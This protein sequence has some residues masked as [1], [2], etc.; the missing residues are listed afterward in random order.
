MLLYT[1]VTPEILLMSFRNKTQVKNS[2]Y[3]GLIDENFPDDVMSL[4]GDNLVIKESKNTLNVDIALAIAFNSIR[5]CDTARQFARVFIANGPQIDTKTLLYY[6]NRILN[7]P[8][9]NCVV[10]FVDVNF[11]AATQG[12]TGANNANTQRNLGGSVIR[13][14]TILENYNKTA[15]YDELVDVSF[16]SF[17]TNAIKDC[18]NA[19]CNYFKSTGSYGLL[20]NTFGTTNTPTT[21]SGIAIAGVDDIETFNKIPPIFQRVGIQLSEMTTNIKQSLA[22][23]V[24]STKKVFT[25]D[26]TYTIK[27]VPISTSSISYDSFVRSSTEILGVVSSNLGDCYRVNDFR[28]RYNPYTYLAD[29]GMNGEVAGDPG[30]N[31]MP[32]GYVPQNNGN[33]NADAPILPSNPNQINI[34]DM[35]NPILPSL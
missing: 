11:E 24:S 22:N 31:G 4:T 5:D 27:N 15:G 20:Y 23:I 8:F 9:K 26:G 10:N 35:V 6:R 18:L 13:N 19:P 28:R 3:C 21:E 2:S 14:T 32:V 17:L 16:V 29:G 34:G 30:I 25:E 1:H 33:L 7:G 12:V